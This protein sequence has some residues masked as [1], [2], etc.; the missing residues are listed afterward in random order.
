M[1]GLV[2]GPQRSLSGH[3]GPHQAATTAHR[4]AGEGK[5]R[6]ASAAGA[7]RETAERQSTEVNRNYLIACAAAIALIAAAYASSLDNSFHFDDSHVIQSNVYI[8]SLH[9]VP[10]FFEDA[11]TFSSL[12]QN[13][14]YRPLV[15]LSLAL[16]YARGALSPR[17]YHV[18]QIALLLVTGALLVA[19]FT[20]LVGEW[21][22]L[23]AAALFCL[24]T[25]NT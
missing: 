15:T 16:D 24:H 2:R 18:T 23:F 14:T 20:P 22:A 13:S 10:L 7:D 8:R 5:C 1:A 19:F 9:N 21:A 4:C 3:R 25:A 17:P 11:H 6:A 12:P